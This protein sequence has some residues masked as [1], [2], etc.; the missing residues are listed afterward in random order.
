MGE[1]DRISVFIYPRNQTQAIK[2]IS[3]NGGKIRKVTSNLIAAQMDLEAIA[4]L[5]ESDS[6]V[7]ITPV[8]PLTTQLDVAVP[9]IGADR[10]HKGLDT[11]GTSYLGENV[12]AGLVD[13]G[14]DL[15]HPDFHHP[16]GSTRIL[17]LWDQTQDNGPRPHGF[18]YGKECD[19][20][21]INQNRCGEEDGLYIDETPTYGHGTHIAGIFAGSDPVYTGM[22][23]KAMIIAV[24]AKMDELSLLD[25]VDYL[26]G[27]AAALNLPA[28]INISLGT[29]EGAHD[30]SSPMEI[31]LAERQGPGRI[32]VVSAGN[33]AADSSG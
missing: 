21:L 3:L 2:E 4:R 17:W 9:L 31:E 22:A 28:V 14:I 20:I 33:E 26:L 12:I 5:A 8:R 13:T 6:V 1:P 7:F 25:G 30:G 29:N 15:S 27:K 11:G 10:V 19:S 23:P 18:D 32:F 24:K 16:D